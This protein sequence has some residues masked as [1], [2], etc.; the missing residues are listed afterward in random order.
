MID[1]HRPPED[2]SEAYK[3]HRDYCESEVCPYIGRLFPPLSDVIGLTLAACDAQ[4]FGARSD[5]YK[6]EA[7]QAAERTQMLIRLLFDLAAYLPQSAEWRKFVAECK[8]EDKR[9]KSDGIATC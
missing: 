2:C 3:R 1:S 9:S 5:G 7:M 6:D 4:S 8:A